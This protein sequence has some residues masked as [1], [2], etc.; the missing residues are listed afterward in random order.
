[1]KKT[2]SHILKS[3][4]TCIQWLHLIVAQVRRSNHTRILSSKVVCTIEWHW[5]LQFCHIFVALPRKHRTNPWYIRVLVAFRLQENL[6]VGTIMLKII[7]ILQV[8]WAE[9]NRAGIQ[10]SFND[11]KLWLQ[12][13]IGWRSCDIDWLN[14]VEMTRWSYSKNIGW[15]L[16]LLR[17]PITG[18]SLYWTNVTFFLNRY[19][20]VMTLWQIELPQWKTSMLL[21][22]ERSRSLQRFAI[23]AV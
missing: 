15:K 18:V 6:Q 14:Y 1:M 2:D 3:V 12:L 22:K 4:Y 5:Y 17:L 13:S 9:T 11:F 10:F 8:Q 23:P 16:A 7:I 21:P 20:V 19:E